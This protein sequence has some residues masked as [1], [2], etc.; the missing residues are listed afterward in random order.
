MHRAADPIRYA[1]VELLDAHTG[2]GHRKDLQESLMPLAGQESWNVSAE[3]GL[4]HRVLSELRVASSFLFD[5]VESIGQLE[6]DRIL[7]PERSIVVV[8]GN[9]LGRWH[10]IR[11]LRVAN[12]LHISDQATFGRTIVPGPKR[13]DR[14]ESRSPIELSFRWLDASRVAQETNKGDNQSFSHSPL[15]LLNPWKEKKLACLRRSNA[16]AECENEYRFTEYEH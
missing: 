12:A 8:Y 7:R 15:H 6:W 11:G 13:H 14:I 9:P 1:L 16:L 4:D 2:M 10:I 5:H 3:D